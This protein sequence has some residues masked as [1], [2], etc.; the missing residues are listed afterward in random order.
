M[1][2]Q[3]HVSRPHESNVKRNAS[4]YVSQVLHT[5]VLL[6]KETPPPSERQ[7]LGFCEQDLG[8]A[9]FD[10]GNEA[11]AQECDSRINFND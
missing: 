4:Y 7:R 9:Y 11:S 10:V 6:V 3:N 2:V 8:R 5:E 1:L